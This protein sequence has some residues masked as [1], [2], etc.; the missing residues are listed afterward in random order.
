MRR[1]ADRSQTA[2]PWPTH[3]EMEDFPP[4]PDDLRFLADVDERLHAPELAALCARI[5][6]SGLWRDYVVVSN[7]AREYQ[8]IFENDFVEVWVCAWMAGQQAALHDHDISEVGISVAD[9]AITERH[10]R[11]GQVDS[12]HVLR[13]GQ[14]QEGG[15][16]YIHHVEHFAGAPA[17]SIHAYSPPMV[18]AGVYREVDG[19]MW[20]ERVPGRGTIPPE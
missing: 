16:G 2:V 18:C 10:M 8:M 7:E 4:L 9:G 15:R 5:R 11:L 6:E 20:R 1:V 17:V 14:Q 12:G 3:Q 19:L 13:A